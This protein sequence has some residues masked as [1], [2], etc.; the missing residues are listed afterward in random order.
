M[1]I[2][3]TPSTKQLMIPYHKSRA[4][5]LIE[6]LVV[7]AIIALLAAILIPSLAR[8][9]EQAKIASCKANCNQI[10]KLVAIYQTEYQGYVPVVFNPMAGPI[11]DVPARTTLLS[12]ALR[13]YN[14]NLGRIQQ[15]QA[16]CDSTYFDPEIIWDPTVVD[17]RDDYPKRY[18]YETKF[19]PDYHVCPFVRDKGTFDRISLPERDQYNVWA[20]TGRFESYWTWLWEGDT[21]KGLKPVSGWGEETHPNDPY[22]GRPKYSTLSFNYATSE[23]ITDVKGRLNYVPPSAKYIKDQPR[24]PVNGVPINTLTYYHR[25]WKSNDARRLRS[26]SLSELTTIFCSM[27]NF[28]Q[29][30]YEIYNPEGHRGN[31]GPG[32]NVVFADAHVEWVKGTRVGWP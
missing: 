20:H 24:K 31:S 29:L 8:A 21:V 10:G 9:R 19:A 23:N 26:G 30:M 25:R 27:G 13:A 5:T 6:V 17:P 32:T 28:M 3:A 11:H 2:I 7:V 22:D 15:V 4:F 18:E 16:E 1:R 14:K 12:L